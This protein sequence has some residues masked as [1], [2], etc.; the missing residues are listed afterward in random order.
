MKIEEIWV[1]PPR[2]EFLDQKLNQFVKATTIAK[3]KNLVLK[4]VIDNDDIFY[5]LFDVND[6]LV[7]YLK[8]TKYNDKWHQVCL[9]QLVQS[10]KGQGYETFLYD[11]VILNEKIQLLSDN[12]LTPS[13]YKLWQRF[14]SSGHFVVKIYNKQTDQLSDD[15][16]LID[17][18][19]Y[20]FA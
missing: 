11:Y 14:Y 2:D 13:S 16:F 6:Q 7:G 9:S 15:I 19:R 20:I 10:Y 8:I 18:N 12:N 3:I 1:N 5:G 17:N 4:K